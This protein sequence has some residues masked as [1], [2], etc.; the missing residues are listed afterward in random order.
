MK[1]LFAASESVPFIKTGGLGDFIG[2]LP[3]FIKRKGIEARI[4]IPRYYDISP[5]LK[6]EMEL[7]T[8][9]KFYLSWREQQCRVYRLER[10]EVIYYFIDNDYYFDRK[11]LYEHHDEAERFAFF[12][13][14][15]LEMLPVLNFKP[16]IIHC[17]DWQTG[18][19]SAYLENDYDRDSL[20]SFY[21]NIKTIF[22]IHNLKYQGVFPA[23]IIDDVLGLDREKFFNRDGLEFH[24]KVNFMKGGLNY[25]DII[26]TISKT[27]AREI[28]TALLGRELDG[29]LR[30]RAD[31][32]YGI[33]N[34]IDYEIYDPAT[35]PH[36]FVNYNNSLSKKKENKKHLQSMLNLPQKDVPLIIIVSRLVEQKGFEL[37]EEII[38][39][40]LN[41]DIQLAVLGSGE[42]R[43]EQ[44]FK[45][46]SWHY[47]DKVSTHITFNE[48]LARKMYAAGDLFLMP[49]KFEPCGTG[50]LISLRYLTI[51]IVR[52]TGGLIDT[53][54]PYNKETKVGTGFSFINF[55]AN[56]LFDC[57]K[58]A[59]GSYYNEE[60]WDNIIKN[61]KNKNFSWENSAEEYMELYHT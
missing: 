15:V 16:D 58:Q 44:L 50:Q 18:L 47:P 49:S 52:E 35:D 9:F 3:K 57:I 23:S 13:K 60:I 25:S 28:Q 8:S 34:G 14:A 12:D 7:V 45:E 11:G 42:Y 19:I 61:I 54:Q 56:D 24:G 21:N 5:G 4:V 39:D 32:L 53:V 36:I 20:D 22:T 59:V 6:D 2:A 38:D 37:L 26:T 46:A 43:F 55:S 10:D 27:Y 33:I 40:I 30:K 48:D 1:I 51:P 17:H 29:L 31:N 41:L